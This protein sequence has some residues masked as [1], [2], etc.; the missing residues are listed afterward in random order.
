MTYPWVIYFKILLWVFSKRQNTKAVK[1]KT[2]NS[3]FV[4]LIQILQ[5]VLTP[6]GSVYTYIVFM[7]LGM[8]DNAIFTTTMHLHCSS[9][10]SMCSILSKANQ[11][12]E[13]HAVLEPAVLLYYTWNDEGHY[14]SL[15]RYCDEFLTV[16]RATGKCPA[17]WCTDLS[18]SCSY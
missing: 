9:Y 12:Y 7:A 6:E 8:A 16:S 5:I 11:R 2:Q 18:P 17:V 13:A 4:G 14:T 1:L 3:I 10:N 15:L